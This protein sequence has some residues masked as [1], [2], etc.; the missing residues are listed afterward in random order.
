EAGRGDLRAPLRARLLPG[1]VEGGRAAVDVLVGAVAG[2]RHHEAAV[3]VDAAERE[4]QVGRR[5]A[6]LGLVDGGGVV[7]EVV[8]RALVPG[9]GRRGLVVRARV[10]DERGAVCARGVADVAAPLLEDGGRARARLDLHEAHAV[11]RG[12]DE[13]GAVRLV[14]NRALEAALGDGP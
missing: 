4:G 13:R 9:G 2:R 11:V 5:G 7:L 6:V 1:V 3:R 10:G 14:V 12:A 8:A